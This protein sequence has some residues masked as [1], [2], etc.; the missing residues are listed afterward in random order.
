MA[1]LPLILPSPGH[2]LRR[3]IA[4]EF[5]RVNLS[6]DAVAEIDSLPLLMSC[7]ARAWA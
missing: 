3:R 6:I 2:G 1:A 5:E 4:L 7:L